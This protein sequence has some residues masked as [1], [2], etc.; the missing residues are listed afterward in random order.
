[1][2]TVPYVDLEKF[3]GTWHEVGRYPHWYEK[4][5]SE[6]TAN[7]VYHKEEG[8][9]LV[10]NRY[11][12]EGKEKKLR[13]KAYVIPGTGNSKFK[14]RSH[15]IMQGDYLIIDLDKNYAWAVVSNSKQTKLWI[16]F[17]QLN[18]DNEVLHPIIRRLMEKGYDSTKIIWTQQCC[19][20]S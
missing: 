5:I 20:Q 19:N 15:W 3:A 12:K 11:I 8:C 10:T 18:V 4:E 14:I 17:R 2:E 13:G 6:A 1:M 9:L 16:L 7:Y